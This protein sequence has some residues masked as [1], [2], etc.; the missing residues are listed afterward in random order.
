[1]NSIVYLLCGVMAVQQI[2]HYRE[3]KDL[4]NRIMSKS[5]T[6]YK[7]EGKTPSYS[8]PAHRRVMDRWRQKGGEDR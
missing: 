1:M 5:F 6:E 7:D 3:R 2:L 4:Y 8:V